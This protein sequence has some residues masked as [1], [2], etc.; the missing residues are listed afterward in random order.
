MEENEWYD[1]RIE[2]I[3]ENRTSAGISQE[4]LARMA[5]IDRTYLSRIESGK[6]KASGS[7]VQKLQM[8]LNVLLGENPIRIMIEYCRIRISTQNVK[9]VMEELMRVKMDYFG[10]EPHAFYGYQSQYVLGD[11]AIMISPEE[12]KG[13]LIELKGAGC[14]Q[15]E[16]YLKAQRR[17][18]IPFFCQVLEMKG[19]FKRIDIAVNDMFGMLDISK[20]IEK[21]ENGEYISKL[22]TYKAYLSGE[23]MG[24][25]EA[26]KD[27]VGRTLYLGS[28]RSNIYFCIY[29]KDYEQYIK[30][31][32]EFCEAEIKNRFELRLGDER[33]GKAVE[34]LVRYEDIGST[35]FGI[36]NQYVTFLD[37]GKGDKRSWKQMVEWVA[38]TGTENRKLRLTMKPEPYTLERTMKW[39]ENQVAPS[40]KMVDKLDEIK[41][42]SY[43]KDMIKNSGL[44]E[45]QRKILERAELKPEEM[46]TQH[47]SRSAAAE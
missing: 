22:R 23:L 27:R 3:R 5:G 41:G 32:Q 26:E 44:G 11:I 13:V 33:A 1:E 31:G 30:K 6:K 25:Q 10:H 2:T 36:I 9:M 37:R 8:S 17:D 7:L 28:T 19:I 21:C 15:F 47:N 38:F 46:I 39:L 35:A 4:Q 29:E 40:L 42:T 18:W 16:S 12:E 43:L 20:L 24:K 34:D 14:R 45:R